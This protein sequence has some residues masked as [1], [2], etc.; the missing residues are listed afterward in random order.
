MPSAYVFRKGPTYYFRL[1]VPVDLR[2]HMKVSVIRWSLD[3]GDRK[4]ALSLSAE[5]RSRLKNLFKL[6]RI[7][8]L[9]PEEGLAPDFEIPGRSS[10]GSTTESGEVCRAERGLRGA[11]RN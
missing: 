4:E 9:G 2:P 5:L 8:N 10:G 7:S 11:L 3:T 6:L 1:W